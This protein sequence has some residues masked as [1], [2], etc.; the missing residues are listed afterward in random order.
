ML[1]L[2]QIKHWLNQSWEEPFKKMID[3]KNPQKLISVH[4]RNHFLRWEIAVIVSQKLIM[5]DKSDVTVLPICDRYG[6]KD[7]RFSL[8]VVTFI[9]HLFLFQTSW[10]YI[11]IPRL[12]GSTECL[13]Q[14]WSRIYWSMGELVNSLLHLP[15]WGLFQNQSMIGCLKKKKVKIMVKKKMLLHIKHNCVTFYL[16]SG[17]CHTMTPA[18]PIPC[19]RMMWLQCSASCLLHSLASCW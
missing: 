8:S 7:K 11:P 10:W 16:N 6:V 13:L 3:K 2:T 14:H 5:F 12:A 15:L 9:W 4:F 17:T 18:F 1:L 19:Q